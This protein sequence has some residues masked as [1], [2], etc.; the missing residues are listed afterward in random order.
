M[1]APNETRAD[2]TERQRRERLS[3]EGA[4]YKEE[5]A[6]LSRMLLGPVAE[7]VGGQR[8]LVVADGA[9]QYIP[10]AALPNPHVGGPEAGPLNTDCEVVNLPSVATLAALRL[11]MAGRVR[12]PKTVAILADPVF[13]KNDPRV[14]RPG[15]GL[16]DGRRSADGS[17]GAVTFARLPYT[18]QEVGAITPFVPAGEMKRALDFE[19][20]R[21]TAISPELGRYRIIHFATHGLV[22]S[23]D[24]HLTALVLSLV[25]KSGRP[26]D[27]FLRLQ[28]VYNMKLGAD[29]VVLSACQT[30]L[31]KEIKGEGLLGLTHGFM[32]AGAPM[33]LASLWEVN[34]R[35][36]VELMGRFYE[37]M[38]GEKRLGPTAALRAAQEA[39]RKQRRWQE[40]YYWAGFVI[41][42]DWKT[43]E[44]LA[45]TLTPLDA[46][47]R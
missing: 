24:P 4:R 17:A 39:M 41:Q 28:D 5:S 11:E 16:K 18:R 14:T 15:A 8:L 42:G 25:D 1:N 21:E 29:L 44:D 46:R 38:L 23:E 2:E 45:R 13:S 9:L 40:P 22:N 33:V 12:A 26:V 6:A 32:Y 30:G 47:V 7:G 37:G 10:F 43:G 3:A 20:S 36:A 31:G 35:A 27:G 19:A 34:D